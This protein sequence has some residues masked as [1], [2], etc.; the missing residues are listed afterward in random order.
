MKL[1]M[2]AKRDAQRQSQGPSQHQNGTENRQLN[3]LLN[4]SHVQK[5]NGKIKTNATP[6]YKIKRHYL[7]VHA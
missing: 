5:Q 3:S 4:F 1:K 7:L 2:R 6:T